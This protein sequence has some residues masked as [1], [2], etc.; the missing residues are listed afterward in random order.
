LKSLIDQRVAQ[1]ETTVG[2]GRE[3]RFNDAIAIA[4]A[5]P[6]RKICMD[7]IIS[8]FEELIA[9]ETQAKSKAIEEVAIWSSVR[10]G[11]FVVLS[12]LNIY[13]IYHAA[14]G[15]AK[16]VQISKKQE[17]MFSAWLRHLDE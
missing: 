6:N 13:V 11:V 5:D 12:V 16:S 15:L 17:E 2:L 7:S 4:R 14:L 8:S 10:S 3:N 1:F 9:L